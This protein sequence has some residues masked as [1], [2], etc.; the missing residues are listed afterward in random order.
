[1]R[2]LCH[3]HVLASSVVQEFHLIL[4]HRCILTQGLVWV[5]VC[6]DYCVTNHALQP[7]N[8]WLLITFGHDTSF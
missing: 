7:S 2:L 3:Y 4:M 5:A 6:V 1:M 8:S